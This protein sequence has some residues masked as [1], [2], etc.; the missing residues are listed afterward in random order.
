[1]K[2]KLTLLLSFMFALQLFAMSSAFA[3]T[4]SYDSSN[5]ITISTTIAP[6]QVQTSDSTGQTTFETQEAV[7]Q[8]VN[9][10]TGQEVSHSYVWVEVNGNQ[11]LAVD[12]PKPC[13]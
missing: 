6:D 13:F 3:A 1:M 8:L 11:V 9:D 4:D 10:S 2:R 7:H 12:P 5:D